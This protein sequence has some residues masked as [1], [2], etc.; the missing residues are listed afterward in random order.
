MRCYSALKASI[1]ARWQF[2]PATW[3][4]ARK[5]YSTY[6]LVWESM[7]STGE[8]CIRAQRSLL[9]AL[10]CYKMSILLFCAQSR[11]RLNNDFGLLH[12]LWAWRHYHTYKLV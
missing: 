11:Y 3:L 2:R 12:G 7:K 8:I 10:R 1:G 4:A 9:N 5:H 6:K